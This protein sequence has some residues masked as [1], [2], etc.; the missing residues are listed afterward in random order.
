MRKKISQ[1]KSVPFESIS[2]GLALKLV[3]SLL[4]CISENLLLSSY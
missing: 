3:V 2:F 1:M 4:K